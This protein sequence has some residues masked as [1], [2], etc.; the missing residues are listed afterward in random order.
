[1]AGNF[2]P[3]TAI[4]W[5]D[6]VRNP[7]MMP[8]LF[9]NTPGEVTPDNNKVVYVEQD[10]S[11]KKSG[12]FEVA[13]EDELEDLINTFFTKPL[14]TKVFMSHQQN[15]S[16]N[17]GRVNVMEISRWSGNYAVLFNI[18]H[19][20]LRKQ[21]EPSL[22]K[23]QEVM[24]KGKNFC[25]EINFWKALNDWYT[26]Q[27]NGRMHEGFNQNW[28]TQCV[29]ATF[30]VTNT[31]IY[32]HCF[33]CNICWCCLCCICWLFSAPCYRCCRSCTTTDMPITIATKVTTKELVVASQAQVVTRQ[34]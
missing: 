25:V 15:T 18:P 32:N 30:N 33:D 6:F 13:T 4:L 20:D 14:F 8:G 26:D 5:D 7:Q 31:S 1:M 34:H 21:I 17:Q 2:P 23:A 19:P 12:V 28:I 3:V 22:R 24:K 16:H 11:N 10:R 9:Q 27:L 29:F